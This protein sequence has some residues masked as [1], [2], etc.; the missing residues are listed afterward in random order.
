MFVTSIVDLEEVIGKGE[1]IVIGRQERN[2]VVLI[3]GAI[4]ATVIDVPSVSARR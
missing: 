2:P 1:E 3:R 4:P